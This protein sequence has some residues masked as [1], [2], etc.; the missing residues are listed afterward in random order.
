MVKVIYIINHPANCRV[1]FDFIDILLRR[2]YTRGV[3]IIPRM[4]MTAKITQ[5]GNIVDIDG[6][7]FE[8]YESHFLC[9]ICGSYQV[10]YTKYD[11][12]FCP[13]CNIWLEAKCDDPECIHCANRPDKPLQ[14]TSPT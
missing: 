12:F 4:K 14:Y 1:I 11:S 6:F 7:E 3:I 13:K 9:N 2:D 5:R 10:F 8:G